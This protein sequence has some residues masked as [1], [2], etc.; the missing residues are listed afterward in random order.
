MGNCGNYNL[1]H[2]EYDLIDGIGKQMW[3]DISSHTLQSM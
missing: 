3:N 2:D 1:S